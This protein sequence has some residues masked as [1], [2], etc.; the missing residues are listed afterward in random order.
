M[1]GAW[2]ACG[3]QGV[4]V[5]GAGHLPAPFVTRPHHLWVYAQVV[6]CSRQTFLS[7]RLRSWL[8]GACREAGHDPLH[9]TVQGF[10][11][12]LLT[13]HHVSQDCEGV[14]ALPRIPEYFGIT[15]FNAQHQLL[16]AKS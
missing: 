12:F 10:S 9:V 15:I 2:V 7:S 5:D 16:Y 14:P 1:G 4:P 3:V 8:C 6:F 11:S 13:N